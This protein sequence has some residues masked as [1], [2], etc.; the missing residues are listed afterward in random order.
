MRTSIGWSR[1]SWSPRDGEP[2]DAWWRHSG[3]RRSGQ[4]LLGRRTDVGRR[5]SPAD[6]TGVSSDAARIGVLA[7]RH[8]RF[9]W[10]ATL[11][12]TRRRRAARVLCDKARS[13]SA[14]HHARRPSS[15]VRSARRLDCSPEAVDAG[16]EPAAQPTPGAQQVD[17]IGGRA[18]DLPHEQNSS[19]SRSPVD[20]HAA[21]PRRSTRR[22]SSSRRLRRPSRAAQPLGSMFAFR[23]KRFVGSYFVLTSARRS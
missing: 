1:L 6:R 20:Q 15:G 19:S 11:L 9:G 7:E 3:R 5:A 16:V 23:R 2:E 4:V 22:R 14:C 21:G 10:Q 18:G 12:M 13:N 8:R 17:L